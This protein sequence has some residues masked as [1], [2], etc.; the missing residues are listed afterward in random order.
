MWSVQHA[1]NVT[2][3]YTYIIAGYFVFSI[4]FTKNSVLAN[5]LAESPLK[6]FWKRNFAAA[7]IYLCKRKE[8]SGI[9]PSLGSH[10]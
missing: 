2:Y 7:E 10:L 5:E 4:I 8:V 3:S 9:S 1:T 6:D